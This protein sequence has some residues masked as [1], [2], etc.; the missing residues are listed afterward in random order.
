MFSAYQDFLFFEYMLS[1][2]WW[3][4]WS[5][6]CT[7][8]ALLNTPTIRAF[9]LHI[10]IALDPTCHPPS[11]CYFQTELLCFALFF[12]K[13]SVWML[14]WREG[15]A[16]TGNKLSI[17]DLRWLIVHRVHD[18]FWFCLEYPTVWGPITAASGAMPSSGSRTAMFGEEH[19]SWRWGT[20]EITNSCK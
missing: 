4:T 14:W 13:R 6:V 8:V 9:F 2:G 17:A 1:S 18:I 16:T 3:V 19:I 10:L 12:S 5:A 20:H 11:W 15:M 7:I